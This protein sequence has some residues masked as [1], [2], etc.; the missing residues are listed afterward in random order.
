MK[1]SCS[2]KRFKELQQFIKEKNIDKISSILE[3][4]KAEVTEIEQ[5]LIYGLSESSRKKD[6][7]TIKENISY[8][9]SG[10]S[11]FTYNIDN[12]ICHSIINIID[13]QKNEELSS[14]DVLELLEFIVDKYLFEA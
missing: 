6:F 3:M 1:P 14:N 10:R 12:V 5:L 8:F 13:M 9:C 4:N 7:G 2:D 11:S